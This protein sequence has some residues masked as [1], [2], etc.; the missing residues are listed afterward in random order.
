[1]TAVWGETAAAPTSREIDCGSFWP[2]IVTGDFYEEYR[3]PGELP[4]ATVEGHIKQAIIR[5]KDALNEWK[6]AQVSAGYAKLENVP[7]EQV[8]GGGEKL[9]L[10]N[11]AV[12]C[13]AKA[14]I[15][16]ETVT[17]DRRKDAENAAKSAPDTEEK[18][19]E[20]AADAL[21]ALVGEDRISIELL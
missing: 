19:R 16:R 13:E 3:I 18:Y 1:M 4:V 15:L 12:F 17:V 8:D 20:F 5:V 10:F 21:R 14:E 11:R 2:K 7:Q 6:L 9:L